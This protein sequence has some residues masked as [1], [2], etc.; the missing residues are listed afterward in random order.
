[1]FYITKFINYETFFDQISALTNFNLPILSFTQD[2]T[3]STQ[4]ASEKDF[5]PN[6]PIPTDNVR[7]GRLSNGLTY[8]IQNNPKPENKVELRLVVTQGPSWKMR[9]S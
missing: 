1:M 9:T 2:I 4:V 8:Y 6:T 5:D 7:I 3:Q